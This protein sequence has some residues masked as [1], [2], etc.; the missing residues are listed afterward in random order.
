MSRRKKRQSRRQRAAKS[1]SPGSTGARPSP[2]RFAPEV[3]QQALDLI[4][5]GVR[6]GT[7]AKRIGCSTE[8]LRLWAR[9]AGVR[10]A[11]GERSADPLAAAVPSARPEPITAPAGDTVP[12]PAVAERAPTAPHDPPAGL[13][14]AEVDG[15]LEYKKRHPTMGPAQIRAQL[16]RFKGWRISLRAIARA[17]RQNGYELQHR[18]GRPEEPEPPRRWEAPYR[19]A[20]WQIDATDLRLADGPWAGV[21]IID[22]FSRFL[23]NCKLLKNPTSEDIVQMLQEAI[24]LHGKPLAIYTDRAGP[25]LCWGREGGLQRFLDEELI[26][27]HV[28]RA[29]RPQGRGKVEAAIATLQ[30]E[31]W[32]VEH[33]SS[34]EEA[35]TAVQ[36]FVERYNHQRAHLGIDGLTPADRFY[37]RW[38]RVLAF[39]QA[40]SRKRQGL[41]DLRRAAGISGEILPE[42]HA[43]VL[44][45]IAVDG[46]LELRFLG[47]RVRLG[48]LES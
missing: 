27:H 19:N 8:T 18:H 25:F 34:I 6:R 10:I 17:L 14:R 20:L 7:I 31:L 5:R 29:Y 1:Q 39:V 2:A 22:D 32:E 35:R 36:A 38:E 48:K 37:G 45:L 26:D 47:H 42:N 15:I 43:E 46:E 33:F 23:V 9:A 4:L 30:R 28:S 41:D 11:T 21:V 24:H 3:R 44:R 12:V 40:E 13:S 16:K